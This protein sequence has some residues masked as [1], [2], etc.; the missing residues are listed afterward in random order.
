[1]PTDSTSLPAT[2][3]ERASVVARLA[4][5]IAQAQH[6]AQL[7]YALEQV[8]IARQPPDDPAS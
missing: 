2:D 5:A 4:L 1:M 6:V 3:D 8:T 7:V